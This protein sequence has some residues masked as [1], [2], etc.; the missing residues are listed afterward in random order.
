MSAVHKL[1]QQYLPLFLFSASVNTF[2]P[3]R[4]MQSTNHSIICLWELCHNL[5]IVKRR[6]GERII[7]SYPAESLIC[8]RRR[9]TILE[10]S[11][12]PYMTEIPPCECKQHFEQC[13]CSCIS[14]SSC[15]AEAVNYQPSLPWPGSNKMMQHTTSLTQ[16]C[17]H[18][19]VPRQH[20]LHLTYTTHYHGTPSTNFVCHR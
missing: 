5:P 18:I 1:R 10:E 13:T 12:A 16:C 7:M 20:L 15:R 14:S 9:R 2:S 11:K 3:Y 6:E 8:R 4:L 19:Y 17:A